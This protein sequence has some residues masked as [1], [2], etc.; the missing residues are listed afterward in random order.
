MTVPARN[1]DDEVVELVGIELLPGP[2]HA[3]AGRGEAQI[4]PVA[5]DVS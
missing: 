3:E 5:V 1:G 4:G 2:S